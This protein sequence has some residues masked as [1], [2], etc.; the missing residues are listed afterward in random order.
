MVARAMANAARCYRI[1]DM[2]DPELMKAEVLAAF[3]RLIAQTADPAVASNET[4]VEML[5]AQTVQAARSGGLLARKTEVD[6]LLR[7]GGTTQISQAIQ[8]AGAKSGRPFLL[9]V[10]GEEEELQALESGRFALGKRL[11]KGELSRV[12]LLRVEKA[13]LLNA[14]RA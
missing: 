3:P 2:Q 6:L 4:V 5:A 9:V 14:I 13:A 12:E 11:P 8:Q 10:A 1:D 7:L